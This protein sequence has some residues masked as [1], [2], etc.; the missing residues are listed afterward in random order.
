MEA[1]TLLDLVLDRRLEGSYY[2][3]KDYYYKRLERLQEML[4]QKQKEPAE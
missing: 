3:R 2:G 4:D 1:E